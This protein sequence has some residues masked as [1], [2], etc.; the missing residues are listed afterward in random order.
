MNKEQTREARDIMDAFMNGETVQYK[1]ATGGWRGATNPTWNFVNYEYRI[2]PK[3]REF[4]I[5]LNAEGETT[6][7]LAGFKFISNPW[8]KII[9]VREVLDDESS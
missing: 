1:K 7:K 5:E 4:W 9:K 3:P 6:G 2:K 8:Y